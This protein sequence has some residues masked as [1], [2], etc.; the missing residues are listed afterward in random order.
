[1]DMSFSTE[2]QAFRAEVRQFLQDRLPARLSEKV[3]LN[4]E[5]T[6]AEI[7]E[8][9][10]VLNEQGWLAGN[11]PRQFGGAGWTAIQRHIFEEESAL[12]HAPR[13][14]ALRHRHAGAGAAEIR[15][16]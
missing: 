5:L 15:Q 8:W 16:P 10:A 11:W 4:R 7:E 14:A 9:H 3:R 13:I 6:K 2:D 12:A 1:M